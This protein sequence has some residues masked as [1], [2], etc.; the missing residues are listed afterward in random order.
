MKHLS[1]LWPVYLAVLTA[2]ATVFLSVRSWTTS[3]VL[4]LNQARTTSGKGFCV[5]AFSLCS[6]IRMK[7][8]DSEHNFNFSGPDVPNDTGWHRIPIN[9]GVTEKS[10]NVWFGKWHLKPN[11]K[12]AWGE[13]DIFI[14][15]PTWM[16]F[17]VGYIPLLM[18]WWKRREAARN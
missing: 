16:I 15:L 4:V 9:E 8:S 13:R 1:R 17:S 5:T 12:Q 3:D 7:I 6:C 11:P 18:W 10:G 14:G 2:V